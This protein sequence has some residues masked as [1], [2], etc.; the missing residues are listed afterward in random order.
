M[1]PAAG[2]PM[3]GKTKTGKTIDVSLSADE[4]Q[5]GNLFSMPVK[6][7]HTVSGN[8]VNEKYP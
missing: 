6:I 3:P 7:R 4:I 2:N 5:R 1:I 8:A